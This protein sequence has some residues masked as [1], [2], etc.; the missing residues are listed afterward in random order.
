MIRVDEKG[1]DVLFSVRVS[2]GAARTCI[3]GRHAGA[4]KVAIAAPAEKDMANRELT[5]FISES[6]GVSKAAVSVTAGRA[7]RTKRVSVEGL[8]AE[9]AAS[10]LARLADA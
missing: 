1:S 10:R 5:S 7:S 6:L 8:S 9:V 2:P 3:L 4:L